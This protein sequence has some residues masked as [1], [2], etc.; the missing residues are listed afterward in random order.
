MLPA[1]A[2]EAVLSRQKLRVNGKS[3]QCEAYN[4]G[5]ANYF[6]LRDLAF[7]LNG[8]ESRFSVDWDAAACAVTV[9]SG[10]DYLPMG[11]ELE[12][13]TDR[14]FSAVPSDQSIY[15]DGAERSDLSVY[16]IGGANYF[17]LRDL[18]GALG[19]RVDYDTASATML[20]ESAD[21]TAAWQPKP[22]PEASGTAQT[23]RNGGVIDRSN[24][25]DGYV[26]AK[27]TDD[28][29][30]RIKVRIEAPTTTY[31]YD[32]K[33]ETWAV[34]PLSDGDG[35][36]KVGIYREVCGGK[37]ALV[38]SATFP[39]LLTDEFAPFLRPNQY[40]N[41]AE[42]PETVAKA[43]ELTREQPTVLGK[44][45]AIY[46]FVLDNLS[47]DDDLAATV[48][49]GY[50]PELDAVL[51]AGKGICF[52]YAAVM[53]AMLRSQ[54]VASKLVVGYAGDVYHAWLRVYSPED[55]WVDA[56]FFDGVSWRRMDPTFADA[57]GNSE[58]IR[59]YIG[60]DGNYLAMYYY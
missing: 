3:V 6:K 53:T 60:E 36:Y 44:L 48:E 51:A 52:D 22:M 57:G 32:L 2:S 21:Y 34:F 43:A 19:F 4:I 30:R 24:A 15:I 20:V 33:P 18:G 50:L 27:M 56:V 55:G 17:K 16:N 37:Y 31:D 46:G 47:Y 49:S 28:S 54:G 10:G 26:M 14:A 45:D 59:G 1:G 7:L 25:Q 38:V 41:Y 40:V 11:G 42:A 58:E 12:T 9:R 23:E 8:T 35:D 5:G 13:G 29:G 39:V